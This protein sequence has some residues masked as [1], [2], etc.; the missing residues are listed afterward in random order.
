M[1]NQDFINEYSERK[2]SF[3]G[4]KNEL[5]SIEGL[6]I[7]EKQSVFYGSLT[8]NHIKYI[9]EKFDLDYLI[10]YKK[11]LKNSNQFDFVFETDELAIY[12]LN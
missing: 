2:N 11:Y 7:G 8:P 5:D 4:K 10:F 6:W 9:R 3:F 1:V 12:S